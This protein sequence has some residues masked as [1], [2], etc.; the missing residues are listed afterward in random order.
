MIIRLV[1][2]VVKNEVH[3]D[4]DPYPIEFEEFPGNVISSKGFV[5][6]DD[7]NIMEEE[8]EEE[9]NNEDDEGEEEDDEEEDEDDEAEE[10]E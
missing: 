10:D 1:I 6:E 5:E 9:E 7:Y 4:E 8:E 3:P 2:K